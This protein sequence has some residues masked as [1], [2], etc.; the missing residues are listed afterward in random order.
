MYR[1]GDVL[2]DRYII[3]GMLG[4]GGSG[5]VYLAEDLGIG[6][7]W[8]LKEV[9]INDS[10]LKQ[11]AKSEITMLKTID[12]PSIPRITDAWQNETHFYIVSDY[13]E[14]IS[15]ERLLEDGP[16][17]K[18]KCYKY[19]HQ[20]AEALE[21]L[22]RFNPPILYLDLKPDNIMVK[23]DGRLYLIDFG[24]SS[25]GNK[26]AG[27]YGTKG[28][29]APEQYM[30]VGCPKV[31][32][33]SDIYAFG[34]TYLTMRTGCN[35]NPD[36]QKQIEIIRGNTSISRS[37][38]RFILNCI[39]VN[40]EYRYG[41]MNQV[42]KHL[43]HIYFFSKNIKQW[44]IALLGI[45][46]AIIIFIQSILKQ[47]N[48]QELASEMLREATSHTED[49]EYTP[50]ALDIIAAYIES[51][52]LSESEKDYYSFILGRIYFEKMQNYRE[53]ERYFGRLDEK[54]YPEKEYYIE[55]C[56]LQTGFDYDRDK[57]S[58]C[59]ERF[60]GSILQMPEG[61]EKYDNLL[62]VAFMY[63]HY[64]QDNQGSKKASEICRYIIER[65]EQINQEGEGED[66]M[67]NIYIKCRNE[68]EVL[69]E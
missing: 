38:K 44:M 27:G 6:K 22:H 9:E 63:Q 4:R 12:H 7:L 60:M 65:I 31:D 15:L 25:F 20:I 52:K 1:A 45:P 18:I 67:E 13:I 53:A 21:F 8:A 51:D 47:N 35:P 33:R 34:K 68:Q 64:L 61:Q 69:D 28:Y 49:G 16:I 17:S 11:F 36:T 30:A 26:G 19:A 10:D 62:F 37:E 59:L 23:P 32:A 14:G 5:C 58:I 66:W 2:K 3:R 55:L 43:E 54:K 39:N 29:A 42:K 40:P 50:E 41:S 57:L 48:A 24:I 46:I 56:E